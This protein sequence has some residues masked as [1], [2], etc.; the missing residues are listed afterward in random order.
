MDTPRG[1]SKRDIPPNKVV[2]IE[3]VLM[4]RKGVFIPFGVLTCYFTEQN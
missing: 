4:T 1:A 3:Q 2:P